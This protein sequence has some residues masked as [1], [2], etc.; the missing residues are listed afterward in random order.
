LYAALAKGGH[1]DEDAVR[2]DDGIPAL[3]YRH[4]D[5]DLD[6]C[7]ADDPLLLDRGQGEEQLKAAHRHHAC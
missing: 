4:L 6:R 2:A 7:I 1:P 5:R 3:P